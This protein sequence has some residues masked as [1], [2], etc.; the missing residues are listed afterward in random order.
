MFTLAKLRHVTASPEREDFLEEG[1][2]IPRRLPASPSRVGSCRRPWTLAKANE[3]S[4][5]WEMPLEI[6]W[7]GVTARM[8]EKLAAGEQRIWEERESF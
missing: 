4:L 7:A 3:F 6:S 8:A 5:T 2:V 1:F